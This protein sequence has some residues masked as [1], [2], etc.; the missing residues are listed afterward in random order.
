MHK[1]KNK[2]K[3]GRYTENWWT[4]MA[5]QYHCRG[6]HGVLQ[7]LWFY[8]LFIYLFICCW[9]QILNINAL[10]FASFSW[11]SAYI[12]VLVRQNSWE[13]GNFICTFIL[14]VKWLVG[15]FWSILSSDNIFVTL[16]NFF[17]DHFR[18]DLCLNYIYLHLCSI[19]NRYF[20]DSSS[21]SY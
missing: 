10:L 17:Y 5:Q 18:F 12:G 6:V 14:L 3:E 21:D 15:P 2:N 19:N 4:I 9:L 11:T 16:G 20:R 8:L 7:R 1:I 13:V